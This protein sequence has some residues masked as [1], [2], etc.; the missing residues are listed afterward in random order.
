MA[1]ALGRR[2]YAVTEAA[3]LAEAVALAA[4]ESPEYAVVDLKM[5]GGSGLELLERLLE[6]DATTR[7]IMLTGYGSIASTVD[8]MRLGAVN[9]LSKPAD[10]DDVVAAFAKAS[11]TPLEGSPVEYQAPS[12]ARTEWEH[13]QRVLSDC[14]GNISETARRLGIHRRTLQR[15]LQTTPPRD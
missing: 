12:L 7:V 11:Q 13:I 1:R 3:N 5:P 8:A 4:E 10:A 2:G 14:G 9:Y 15:K 6:I